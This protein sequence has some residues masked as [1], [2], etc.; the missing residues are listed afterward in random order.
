LFYVWLWS[1]DGYIGIEGDDTTF[2]L[3]KKYIEN[4]KTY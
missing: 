3:I 2:D 1:D 4:Q